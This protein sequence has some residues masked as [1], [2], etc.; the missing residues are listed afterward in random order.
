MTII[1]NLSDREYHDSPAIGSTTAVLADT[2][3]RLFGDRVLGIDKQEDRPHFEIGRL[4]HQAVLE[5][6]LFAT[7]VVTQ[8]PTNPKT[9]EPYGRGTKAFAAWQEENPTLTVVEP[10]IHLAIERMPENVCEILSAGQNEMSVFQTAQGVRVKCRPDNWQGGMIWDL[11]TIADADDCERAITRRKYWFS[12]A[13]YRMVCELE[14]GR[15]HD[16]GFIFVEKKAPY[17]WRVVRLAADYRM[18]ADG[19]CREVLAMIA[20]AQSSLCYDDPPADEILVAMP[21]WMERMNETDEG[22]DE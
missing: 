13:W 19:R 17:R 14:T 12:Q 3:I 4:V 18:W 16:M 7:R 1:A 21:D 6:E 2:S 20:K 9:G 11:K 8:G 5:P 22:D 15:P 10:W